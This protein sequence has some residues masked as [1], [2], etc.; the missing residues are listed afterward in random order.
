MS[1]FGLARQLGVSRA[2]AQNYIDVYFDR[3][4]GVAEYMAHSRASAREKGFVE[5][6]F[7]RRLYVPEIGAKHAQRRQAAERT[8]INAPMQGT[9]ADVIKIAMC[10]VQKWLDDSDMDAQ[11]IMQVHDELVFEVETSSVDQVSSRVKELMEAAVELDV[12][13]EV[14]VGVGDNWDQAH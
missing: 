3:Y 6:V 7:G 4:P 13:L 10:N 14:E 5:T 1:A 8:A 2:V 12:L 11:M 9:A